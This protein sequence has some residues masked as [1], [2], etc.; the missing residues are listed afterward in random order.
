MTG[1]DL[2]QKIRK[3]RSDIPVIICAGCIDIL[4]DTDLSKENLQGFIKKPVIGREFAEMMRKI[5]DSS[6]GS[7]KEY[8]V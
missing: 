2:I 7:V 5:L 4:D 8:L 3:V 6:D 1:L